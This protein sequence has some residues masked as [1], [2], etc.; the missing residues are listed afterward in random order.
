MAYP[1]GLAQAAPTSDSLK[2]KQRYIYREL[3]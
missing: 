2:I 1:G 3:S